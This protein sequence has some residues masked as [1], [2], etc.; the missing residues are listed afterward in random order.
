MKQLYTSQTRLIPDYPRYSRRS[1]K[2]PLTRRGSRVRTI[3]PENFWRWRNR[4]RSDDERRARDGNSRKTEVARRCAIIVD[5][6]GA[7]RL[8]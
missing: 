3:V 2:T 6:E 1:F 5:E 7:E 4:R 8:T